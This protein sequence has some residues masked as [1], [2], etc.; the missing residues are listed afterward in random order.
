M[1]SSPET[2]QEPLSGAAHR[3]CSELRQVVRDLSALSDRLRQSSLPLRDAP[4]LPATLAEAKERYEEASRVLLVE[5]LDQYLRLRPIHRSLEAIAEFRRETSAYD[6]SLVARLESTLAQMALEL[7]EPWRIRRSRGAAE[8]WQEWDQRQVSVQE[9]AAGILQ[10]FTDWVPAAAPSSAKADLDQKWWRQQRAVISIFEM[11]L[12]VRE[13]GLIWLD[14]TQGLVTSLREERAAIESSARKTIQWTAG[15]GPAADAFPLASPEERLNHWAQRIEEATTSRLPEITELVEP[16]TRP[17]W[18]KVRPRDAFRAAQVLHGRRALQGIVEA[19]WERGASIAR[20]VARAR[21]LVEYWHES[22][23][24]ELLEEARANAAA[25]LTA[26]LADAA[27]GE[28]L[29]QL[30]LASFSAWSEEGYAALEAGQ[31]GW[32]ALLQRERGWRLLAAATR[33]SGR[34]A[35]RVLARWPNWAVARWDDALEFL[36]WRL[37]VRPPLAPVVRRPT[38]RDTLLLPASKLM[39]PGI[40]RSLF[41]VAPVSDERFLVGRDLEISG[42]AQA[43]KD[44]TDGRFAACLVV[45]ARGSGKTSLLNCASAGI[46]SS[47]TLL[48]RQFRQRLE[49]AEMV[50]AFLREA[51]GV[52]PDADLELAFAAERRVLVIEEFERTFLR[53]VGGFDAVQ[54]LVQWIHKTAANTLWVVSMN[55]KALRVLEAGAAFSQ[56]FSHRINAMSVSRDDLENA[57]LQRHRLSGLS[58]RFAP[59]PAGDPRVSRVRQWL[60]LE[61]PPQKLYFDSLYEQSGGVFRS[62]FELWG[63]SIERV[64]G[65]TVDIRQPLEP[66]FAPLRGALAQA[67]HFTLQAIQEHGSMTAAELAVVLCEPDSASRSRMDRLAALG[68]IERDPEHL[69]LRVRPEAQRFVN[70]LLQRV[71]L[72]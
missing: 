70:D 31:F 15:G 53:R 2:A 44:W 4:E 68:L 50:D 39:L 37:P 43:L 35:R 12:A 18:R 3:L 45:G 10:E 22:G 11:E 54:H 55:D 24:P 19:Y 57:I 48:R 32:F 51:L 62:A 20:D 40:Y 71:N 64:E 38:L 36:G 8:E 28:E 25:M 63:S 17:T 1:K 16:G 23:N 52:A 26:H 14:E 58:L 46:F 56:V 69:G 33:S 27:E 60:E 30:P 42:L 72:T 5:P 59:P 66:R 7:C 47:Y 49:N 61:Q 9:E 21:E 13:L 41:Q 6:P 29:D 65:E 67:D 34:E